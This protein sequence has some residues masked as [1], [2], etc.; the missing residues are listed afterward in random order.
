MKTPIQTVWLFILMLFCL[1]FCHHSAYADAAYP[2]ERFRPTI[3]LNTGWEN[4]LLNGDDADNDYKTNNHGLMFTLTLGVDGVGGKSEDPMM[5]FQLEQ[6]LGFI[7]VRHKDDKWSEKKCFKGATLVGVNLH[8]N[9]PKFDFIF[10]SPKIGVGAVYMK[11]P[12]SAAKSIQSWFAVRPSIAI[13]FFCGALFIGLEFDYT[14]GLSTPNVFDHRR[15][16]HFVSAKL[17][18]WI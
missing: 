8:Q 13:N 12:E 3:G 4:M 9:L 11:T 6:D 5:G 16:T 2:G 10:I 15:I 17:K 14:L 18:L 7:N 1:T